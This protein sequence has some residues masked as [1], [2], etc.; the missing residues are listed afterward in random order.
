MVI[1]EV[2][3]PVIEAGLKETEFWLPSPEAVSATEELKPPV[4]VELMVTLPEPLRAMLIVVG[5]ALMEKPEVTPVT[6]RLTVVVS[7]V[8]PEVPVTVML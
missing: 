8:L 4:A 6:V 7:T 5:D 1:V 2:P 3:L